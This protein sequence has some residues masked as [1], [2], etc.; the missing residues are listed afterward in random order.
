MEVWYTSEWQLP[1][2]SRIAEQKRSFEVQSLK[3]L[4]EYEARTT[5]AIVRSWKCKVR[6][7]FLV[8]TQFSVVTYCPGLCIYIEGGVDTFFQ[9]I[10]W[11]GACQL[12]HVCGGH[13]IPIMHRFRY[14][15]GPRGP[16]TP[17][18]K[19]LV[20][21]RWHSVRTGSHRFKEFSKEENMLGMEQNELYK[22]DVKWLYMVQRHAW[23]GIIS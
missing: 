19:N 11:H 12:R 21:Q 2:I 6:R 14:Q 20:S 18:P 17:A 23:S 22:G 1:V 10:G 16:A 3:Q 15:L 13:P 5:E 4:L 9:Q 7:Y 8:K